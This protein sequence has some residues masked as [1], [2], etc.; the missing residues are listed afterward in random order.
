MIGEYRDEQA[1][2]LNSIVSGCLAR[3]LRIDDDADFVVDEIVGVVGKNSPT[4]FLATD[5]APVS[6]I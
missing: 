1:S 2:S 3:A 5:V 6:V 4:P